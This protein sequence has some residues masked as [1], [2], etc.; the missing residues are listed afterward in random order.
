[1]AVCGTSNRAVLVAGCLCILVAAA[2]GCTS[3]TKR[4]YLQHLSL[5]VAPGVPERQLALDLA[6]ARGTPGTPG[7]TGTAIAGVDTSE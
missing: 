5:I 7:T 6:D 3:P 2:S 1:M 4:Q